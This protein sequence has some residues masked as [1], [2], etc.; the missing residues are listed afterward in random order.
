MSTAWRRESG[1]SRIFAGELLHFR[2]AEH[3]FSRGVV[4][5]IAFTV[6]LSSIS[7]YFFSRAL[8]EA[9]AAANKA[10]KAEVE[11]QF[12]STRL[13]G[14]I[15]D[16]L[17]VLAQALEDR[18]RY[19]AAQQRVAFIEGVGKSEAGISGGSKREY[20]ERWYTIP[21][22]MKFLTIPCSERRTTR[23]FPKHL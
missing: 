23:S 22:L 9:G 17:Q 5:L 11:M 14:K 8:T 12:R 19:A 21:L 15:V 7:G 4:V 10:L 1:G 3:P 16:V 18:A 6:L 2:P 20:L 13:Q